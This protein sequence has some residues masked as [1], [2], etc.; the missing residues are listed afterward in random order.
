M[1]CSRCGVVHPISTPC[2]TPILYRA[3]PETDPLIGAELGSYRVVRPIGRGGMGTV[4]LAEQREIGSK[5][6]IK[7]LHHHLALEPAIV[8]RFQAEARATNLVGHENIVSIFD[9]GRQEPHGYYMVMEYLEGVALSSR[10]EPYAPAEAVEILVQ[11]CDALGAAHRAGVVH[12]DLKPDNIFLVRRG[13]FDRFVK[14]LDFGIAKLFSPGST[15][16]TAAHLILGTP[17]FMSP[18]QA[19]GG[20]VDGRADLYALGIVGYALLCGALPFTGGWA[21][22]MLAHQTQRPVPPSEKVPGVPP[23]LSDVI[24]RALEKAPGDRFQTAE[25]FADALRAALRPQGAMTPTPSSLPLFEAELVPLSGGASRKVRLAHLTKAGAFV[26]IEG[27]L[28]P[29]RERLR[30][31]ITLPGGALVTDAEVVRHVAPDQAHAW[32][33]PAG[34]ALQ[35]SGNVVAKKLDALLTG[36]APAPAPTAVPKQ[37][38]ALVEE[39]LRPF[40]GRWN[41]DPYTLLELP[42]DAEFASIRRALERMQAK[43]EPLRALTLS[44]D[45]KE[46]L[47]QLVERVN[48]ARMVLTDPT[49]RAEFDA[50]LG[51]FRGVARCIAAGLNVTDLESCHRRFLATNRKVQAAAQIHLISA[52]A[53][54]SQGK[55]EE[56]L[57]EY[58][59]ALTKDPLELRAHQRYWKLRQS[60][61]RVA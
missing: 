1:E 45:Q 18:E 53:W 39:T 13:R 11:V 23:A 41:A 44:A 31:T 33:M 38:A 43:L 24:L 6:A 19:S 9:F 26:P 3:P 2:G 5:V 8:A 49:R 22:V 56:A 25:E 28:F 60:G 51:N 59:K 7:V 55:V 12:R 57:R 47:Q 58:E 46:K 40:R 30:A 16:Q 29:V 4:Y 35:F 42:A 50:S 52:E 36:Q 14:V 37:N 34:Y 17:E 20:T 27:T 48:H 54:E 10:T 21:K 15:H 61:Q 32:G